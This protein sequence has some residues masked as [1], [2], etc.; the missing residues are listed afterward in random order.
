MVVEGLDIGDTISPSG[1]LAVELCRS[2]ILKKA[3]VDAAMGNFAA[4]PAH[5]L[6]ASSGSV[7]DGAETFAGGIG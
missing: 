3:A 7:A 1:A 2:R 5:S 6:G 4:P